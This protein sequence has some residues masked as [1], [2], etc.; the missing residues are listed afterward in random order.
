V[1]TDLLNLPDDIMAD[2]PAF[3]ENVRA[4]AEK[5][6]KVAFTQSRVAAAKRTFVSPWESFNTQKLSAGWFY[7]LGT[8]SYSVAGSVWVR[9]VNG[10]WETELKS[11]VYI[12]DRYNWY[13]G[14]A[15]TIGPFTFTDEELGRMHLV[16]LAKEYNVRG[17]STT[18]YLK[19]YTGGTLP[20]PVPT[21]TDDE[22]NG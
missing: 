20:T 16:G 14:K 21:P 5:F 12:F 3:K 9:K 13:G 8:F 19:S 2:I 10:P 22:F 1:G 15:T 17:T 4:Q 6:A 7:A 18:F 11:L